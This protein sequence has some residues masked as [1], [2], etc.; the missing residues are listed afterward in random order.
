MATIA[1]VEA[2]AEVNVLTLKA[3]DSVVFRGVTN[4]LLKLLESRSKFVIGQL[5][6]VESVINLL[7]MGHII[8]IEDHFGFHSPSMFANIPDGYV[9]P[10]P[11]AETKVEIVEDAVIAIAET[12]AEAVPVVSEVVAAVAVVETVVQIVEEAK[13]EVPAAVVTEPVV[14]VPA[15]EPT[16]VVPVAVETTIVPE[17]VIA[18]VIPEVAP[19]TVIETAQ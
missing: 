13:T 18:P 11:V 12:V 17:A 9:A 2:F 3:G 8:S 7:G 14:I 6:T 19:A 5:Y 16:A 15:I 4:Q 1:E 10:T